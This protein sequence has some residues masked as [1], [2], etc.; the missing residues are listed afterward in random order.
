M[1][2]HID[3]QNYYLFNAMSNYLM[4]FWYLSFNP[5]ALDIISTSAVPATASSPSPF[6]LPEYSWSP[7]I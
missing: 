3:K 4:I 1:F 2:R 5:L 7:W 6:S